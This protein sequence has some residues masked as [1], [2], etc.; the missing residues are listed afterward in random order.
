MRKQKKI[1][2]VKYF[3]GMISGYV[4]LFEKVKPILI[5]R[6]GEIEFESEIFPFKHTDYYEKEMGK[7]LK[8][9][10]ISFKP[11]KKP[12]EIVDLKLYC[13]EIEKKFMEQG[14]RKI[15]LDPGYVELSKVVLSTTKNY[16]HRIYLSKGI[17]AE[18]TLYYQNGDFREFHYTYPDY[19]T[20]EYK[21]F[22]RKIRDS[23]KKEV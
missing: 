10:F 14:R 8:R 20:E 5:Q 9:K 3:V 4:D 22:F 18:V 11:L 16:S 6:F 7:D 21:V 15:N 13:I 19:R 1:L 2:P 17:Y 12:D 23:L